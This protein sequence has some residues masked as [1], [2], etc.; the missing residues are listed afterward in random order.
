MKNPVCRTSTIVF[1]SKFALANFESIQ[2]YRAGS[3]NKL[4][5]ACG[6]FSSKPTAS[7][8]LNGLDLRQ[9]TENGP[10]QRL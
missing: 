7:E 2:D 5:E 8:G 9:E 4:I 1:G 10:S 3:V 6:D